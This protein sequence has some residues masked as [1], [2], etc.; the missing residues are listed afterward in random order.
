MNLDLIVAAVSR[1]QDK[2]SLVAEKDTH[3]ILPD[4][5]NR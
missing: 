5:S 3:P 2:R 1:Q 4:A